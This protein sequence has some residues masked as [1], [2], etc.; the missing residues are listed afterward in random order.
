MP[1]STL[2]VSNIGKDLTELCKDQLGLHFIPETE[3]LQ[4]LTAVISRW[5]ACWISERNSLTAGSASSAKPF[6]A[7]APTGATSHL[8]DEKILSRTR[9][10]QTLRLKLVH[11]LRDAEKEDVCR[12]A[13]LDLLLKPRRRRRNEDDFDAAVPFRIGACHPVHRVSPGWLLPRCC[14]F[15]TLYIC[16]LCFQPERRQEPSAVAIGGMCKWRN[17]CFRQETPTPDQP[18]KDDPRSGPGSL[19]FSRV[20][21]ALC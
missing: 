5:N 11:L 20:Q 13:L 18:I 17:K 15:G 8:V 10:H 1:A 6:G 2:P 4:D 9:S 21:W 12:C 14:C 16:G 19:L 3:R 7:F